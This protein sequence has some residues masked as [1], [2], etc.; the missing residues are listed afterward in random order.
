ML[1]RRSL[2]FR[3]YDIVIIDS[4]LCDENGI[5]LAQ[6]I[7][8]DKTISVLLLTPSHLYSEIEAKLSYSGI[9]LLK[10]PINLFNLDSAIKWLKITQD[11]VYFL[12]KEKIRVEE[13]MEEIKLVNRAKWILIEDLK[14]SEKDAQNFII[15]EAMD[16]CIS[17][18]DEAIIII[19]TYRPV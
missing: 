16:K 6:E 4:P 2:L 3:P 11:R 9:F 13:K 14:M 10:K 7:A 1:A 15:K 17:K 19:N 12:E 18:K 5:T 8:K